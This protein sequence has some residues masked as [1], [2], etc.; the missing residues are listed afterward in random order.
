MNRVASEI[1]RNIRHRADNFEGRAKG[2]NL[3]DLE[4]EQSQFAAS[5][6]R[7][8]ATDLDI[9]YTRRSLYGVSTVAAQP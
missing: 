1:V 8:L 9:E 4:R 3:P 7:E 6:L 2:W 5:L